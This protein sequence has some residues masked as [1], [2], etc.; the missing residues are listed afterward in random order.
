MSRV[1][2]AAMARWADAADADMRETA[3]EWPVDVADET[4]PDGFAIAAWMLPLAGTRAQII[5]RS[6][7]RADE[8]MDAP[9]RDAICI[10]FLADDDVP[11]APWISE[12]LR[13][14][15]RRVH[16]LIHLFGSIGDDEDDYAKTL[17]GDG[18]IGTPLRDEYRFVRDM[19]AD[20][21]EV[22]S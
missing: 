5:L 4:V 18:L 14:E 15:G 9:C 6:L 8:S 22:Q 3:L 21:D 11:S 13:R 16:L 7:R 1:I 20:L 12:W 17:L 19:R 10:A 2:D